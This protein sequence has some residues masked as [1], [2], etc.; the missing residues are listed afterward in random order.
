MLEKSLAEQI[1]SAVQQ[2]DLSAFA[3]Q[4]R[5]V[6]AGQTSPT[7]VEYLKALVTP[8]PKPLTKRPKVELTSNGLVIKGP[9]GESLL[10]IGAPDSIFE[11]EGEGIKTQA[12]SALARARRA[13]AEARKIAAEARSSA[14]DA[15]DDTRRQARREA[16]KEGW[17]SE[18][19]DLT[20]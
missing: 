6:A 7:P 18:A 11:G 4:Q 8:S 16:R 14:E 20:E 15:V 5:A 9:R 12:K 2:L 17:K 13:A 19:F 10:S 3:L 1:R